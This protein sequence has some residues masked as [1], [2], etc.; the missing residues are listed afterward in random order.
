MGGAL[1]LK[2]GRIVRD[3]IQIDYLG[4]PQLESDI[5]SLPGE[6]MREV[7]SVDSTTTNCEMGRYSPM[8]R[9]QAD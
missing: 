9:V 1:K 6:L 7:T 8:T 3:D 2:T 4:K 5:C